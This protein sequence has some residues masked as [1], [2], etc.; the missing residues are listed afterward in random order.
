M[1]SGDQRWCDH[2]L[3]ASFC[4]WPPLPRLPTTVPCRSFV[5]SKPSP[6]SNSTTSPT[7]S[8][9][10]PHGA[11]RSKVHGCWAVPRIAIVGAPAPMS[12]WHSLLLY[13]NGPRLRS[14]LLSPSPFG[15]HSLF[16]T[17]PV[18]H[19]HALAALAEPP[20]FVPVGPLAWLRLR[21]YA[22]PC[23]SGLPLVPFP[24]SGTW[25]FMCRSQQ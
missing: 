10:A 19:P 15:P 18:L 7:A 22:V 4:P 13:V 16:P 5:L 25:L 23:S 17:L 24:S 2:A 11:V 8:A 21:P 14:L 1:S 12:V 20:P 6:T 9:C 3:F